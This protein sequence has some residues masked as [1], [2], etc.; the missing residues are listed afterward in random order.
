M[1]S[2]WQYINDEMGGWNEETGLP[3]FCDEPGFYDDDDEVEMTDEE[4]EQLIEDTS[5]DPDI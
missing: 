5:N 1:S 3:N 2:D 4:I